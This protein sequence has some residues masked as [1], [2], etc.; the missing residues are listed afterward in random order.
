MSIINETVEDITRLINDINNHPC[1][2]TTLVYEHSYA[3]YLTTKYFMSVT[4]V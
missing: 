4:G 2:D 3:W 1:R